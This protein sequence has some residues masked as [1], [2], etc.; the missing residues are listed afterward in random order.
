[1]IFDKQANPQI[2]L[3]N[4]KRRNIEAFF[5]TNKKE[6]SAKILDIIP[7]Q[8][9]VGFSGSQTLKELGVVDLLES[10]G[11]LVFNHSRAGIA[12]EESMRIRKESVRSDFYLASPNAISESGELVFFSAYGNRIS[13][14]VF[15]DCTVLICGINKLEKNLEGALKRAREYATPLNCKRLNWNTACVKD[16]ICRENICFAPEYNRM[17]CQILI[18]EYE[19]I[20]GRMKLILVGE[21][22]GF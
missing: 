2:F 5:C 7:K 6:A 17:C 19:A 9:K 3:D 12:P 18:V 1:M 11:N 22:L 16:G 15:A 8:A 10:R 21:K 20:L 14:I 13:G 4:L